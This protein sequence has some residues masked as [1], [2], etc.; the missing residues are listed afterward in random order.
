MESLP[1][2][3]LVINHS[4]EGFKTI[5]IS[6]ESFFIYSADADGLYGNYDQNSGL[7][8]PDDGIVSHFAKHGLEMYQDRGEVSQ[9]QGQDTELLRQF[10]QM[11]DPTFQFSQSAIEDQK[12][13]LGQMRNGGQVL[14][15]DEGLIQELI[16]AGA[17][18]K[19][20]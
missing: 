12:K 5:Y 6:V 14:D 8:R 4:F 17:D 10:L 9:Q 20:L 16:A 7:L 11:S 19:I 13:S 1:L 2:K 15:L 3:F 18:I